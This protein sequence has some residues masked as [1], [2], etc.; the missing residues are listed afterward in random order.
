MK[1]AHLRT[2][3][4][5]HLAALLARDAGGL[6]VADRQVSWSCT[7]RY[8]TE[9]EDKLVSGHCRCCPFSFLYLRFVCRW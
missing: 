3:Q 2:L 6:L 4:A 8:A 7:D 5:K 9:K 1:W